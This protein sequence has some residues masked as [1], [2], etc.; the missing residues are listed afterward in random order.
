MKRALQPSVMRD[1]GPSKLTVG[2][3]FSCTK[4]KEGSLVVLEVKRRRQ[5]DG[6]NVTVDM[7]TSEGHVVATCPEVSAQKLYQKNCL[8]VGT[9]GQSCPSK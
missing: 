8:Q 4:S 2:R 5:E 9:D 7:D 3:D 6:M 1:C